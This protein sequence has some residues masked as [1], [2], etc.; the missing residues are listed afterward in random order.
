MIVKIHAR[1]ENAL[2]G[3]TNHYKDSKKFKNRLQLQAYGV[4]QTL[5]LEKKFLTVNF[6]GL[7]KKILKKGGKLA[8][9]SDQLKK[10]FIKVLEESML[11]AEATKKD[12][13]VIFY[14]N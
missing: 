6:Q 3:L 5:D 11:K 7:I 10:D 12:Y 14:D 9:F 13:E 4:K 8:G 1:T 2:K